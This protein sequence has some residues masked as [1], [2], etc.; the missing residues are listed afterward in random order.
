MIF[1]LWVTAHHPGDVSLRQVFRDLVEQVRLARELG[2]TVRQTERLPEDALQA[3]QEPTLL[4]QHLVQLA[5]VE[6]QPLA[7]RALVEFHLAVGDRHERCGAL[8]APVAR[9]GQDALAL[10]FGGAALLLGQG[11]LAPLELLSGEVLFFL[12]A[13]GDRHMASILSS[14][15]CPLPGGRGRQGE[16]FDYWQRSIAYVVFR[17]LLRSSIPG[18][19]LMVL[20]VARAAPRIA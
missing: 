11:L 10:P 2:F 7:T 15:P 12:P 1:G 5:T 8:G 13:R 4:G 6:P 18:M 14:P 3:A 17:S 20:Q 16:G 19:Y 9:D